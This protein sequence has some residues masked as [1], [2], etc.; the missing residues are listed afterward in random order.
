MHCLT[1]RKQKQVIAD[2]C[3]ISGY[4]HHIAPTD[5]QVQLSSLGFQAAQAGKL[6]ILMRNLKHSV[7]N[8]SQ[9]TR[10]GITLTSSLSMPHVFCYL[11]LR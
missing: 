6:A 9:I 11:L 4:F 1:R 2:I 8:S 10:R 5:F 3:Y 7:Y